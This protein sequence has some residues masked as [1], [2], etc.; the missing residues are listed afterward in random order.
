MYN[1]RYHI[2]SLV[3]IFLAL[4]LGLILGGLVVQQGTVDRQQDALVEGLRKEF[5]DLRAENDSV[6]QQNEDLG[7]FA[8]T[9]VEGWSRDRLEG[10]TYVILSRTGEE[11]AVRLVRQT[12]EDAGG[13][14]AV[15]R[16]V[17]DGL[18]LT[19]EA[20]SEDAT[21]TEDAPRLQSVAASLA[22]EWHSIDEE[23]PVTD[24]LVESGVLSLDGPESGVAVSGV[25]DVA[26]QGVT[27]DE[28]G[29]AIVAAFLKNGAAVA[30][31]TREMDTGVVSA[32]SRLGGSGVD[33][34]DTA[35]GR[36]SLVAVLSGSEAGHY[37]TLEGA[38]AP[39]APLPER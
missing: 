28:A 20:S 37:G 27:A 32:V 3:G 8:G 1:L 9:L 14:V 25:I 21:A 23:R 10:E 39:Y 34:I 36:Y 13:S 19:L 2:A 38:V 15:A 30:V 18:G 31:Q 33:D 35:A 5:A 29:I 26:A 16:V 11:P 7:E 4:A 24:G 12:I 17:E 22:A 6:T